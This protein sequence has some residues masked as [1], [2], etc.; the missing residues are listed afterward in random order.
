MT[1]GKPNVFENRE[2][3]D[4]GFSSLEKKLGGNEDAVLVDESG[5]LFGVFDGMGGAAA[6]EIASAMARDVIRE[7]IASFAD[8]LDPEEWVSGIADALGR[9]NDAVRDEAGNDE[10][11][12]G[13][14]TTAV[15]LK[16]L[17]TAEGRQFICASVGDS[18]LYLLREGRLLKITLDDNPVLSAD[19]YYPTPESKRAAQDRLDNAESR[20][21][22]LEEVDQIAFDRRHLLLKAIGRMRSSETLYPQAYREPVLPGDIF[23]LSSDGVHDN[24]I[25]EDIVEAVARGGTARECAEALTAKAREVSVSGQPR[26]KKDDMTAI[27]VKV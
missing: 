1:E 26:S 24:L 22:L 4:V 19:Q 9:A 21:E 14:G 16:L 17:D 5:L 3:P 2:K 6:G 10:A 15:V 20:K 25:D 13:M 7:R 12:E 23:I 11:K 8:D 18:R 27:V